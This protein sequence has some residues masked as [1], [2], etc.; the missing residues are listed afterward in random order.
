MDTEPIVGYIWNVYRPWSLFSYVVCG[1][2][3]CWYAF[4][5]SYIS[6]YVEIR[7]MTTVQA[8]WW[9][10]I[11]ISLASL[12]VV[13]WMWDPEFDSVLRDRSV[14]ESIIKC[15]D[16]LTANHLAGSRL[17]NMGKGGEYY[18][19]NVFTFP[20]AL[21]RR[22][23]SGPGI[24]ARKFLQQAKDM[25][26]GNELSKKTRQ[27]LLSKPIDTWMFPNGLY[28]RLIGLHHQNGKRLES[29][30]GYFSYGAALVN[31]RESREAPPWEEG[32]L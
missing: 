30:T 23:L 19:E 9:L 7:Y 27:D 17:S 22:L 21:H 16:C 14:Y 11:Q 10:G 25:V 26:D 28:S 1:T 31:I 20:A 24:T 13:I 15:D 3:L 2:N 6:Q 32:E 4:M 8:A 12:R 5:S 18:H 29:P